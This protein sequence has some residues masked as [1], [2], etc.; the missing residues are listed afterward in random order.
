VDAGSLLLLLIAGGMLV[1]LFTRM[2]RQQ[3]ETASV[4]AKVVPGVEVMTAGGLFATV[5]EV[6]DGVVVLETAPGQR[7]R[8][9]RRAVARVITES[10]EQDPGL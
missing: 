6:E 5:V 3:Q 2:R 4:Q 8:W 7:S 1:L 10:G 9:D